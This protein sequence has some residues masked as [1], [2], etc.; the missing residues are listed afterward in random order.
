MSKQK[1]DTGTK[2]NSLEAVFIIITG[3]RKRESGIKKKNVE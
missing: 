3:G 1:M 2:K